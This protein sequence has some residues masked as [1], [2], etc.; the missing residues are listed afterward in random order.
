[1]QNLR[2]DQRLIRRG[3]WISQE[4]LQRELEALPDVTEKIAPPETG[5]DDDASASDESEAK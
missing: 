4:E 5:S 2:L 3:G 1:M